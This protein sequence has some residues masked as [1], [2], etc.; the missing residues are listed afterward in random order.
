MKFELN[1]EKSKEY[2]VIVVGS[3]PVGIGAALLAG[4]NGAK[5]LLI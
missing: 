4:R 1:I 5:T 2:D 3:G